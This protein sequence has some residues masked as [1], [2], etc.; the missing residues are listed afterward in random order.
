MDHLGMSDKGLARTLGFATAAILALT[1]AP[2]GFVRDEGY[3]FTAAQ[4]AA[5]RPEA[6]MNTT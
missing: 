6:E 5:S 1:Q 2:V 4:N 3:Y